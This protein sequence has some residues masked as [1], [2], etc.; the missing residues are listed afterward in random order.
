MK[1]PFKYTL[2][3]LVPFT[4]SEKRIVR[5]E[6]FEQAP[7]ITAQDYHTKS[8][9]FVSKKFRSW[10]IRSSNLPEIIFKSKSIFLKGT[11]HLSTACGFEC[12]KA[13]FDEVSE[14]LKEFREVY[15][16]HK[17]QQHPLTTIF[18]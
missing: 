5:F 6:I 4:G 15:C 3:P 1:I 2:K 10:R 9:G 14:V 7:E 17:D 18:K 16:K 8:L 13:E 12:T 11:E